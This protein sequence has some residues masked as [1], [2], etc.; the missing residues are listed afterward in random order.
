MRVGTEFT[1]APFALVTHDLLDQ[2]TGNARIEEPRDDRV[3]PSVRVEG[4]VVHAASIAEQT[5]PLPIG[6]RMTGH[7]TMRERLGKQ[8]RFRVASDH[9]SFQKFQGD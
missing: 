2:M 3:A 1:S 4:R 8:R 5:E 6:S 7:L 9:A